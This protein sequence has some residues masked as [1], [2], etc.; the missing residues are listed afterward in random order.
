MDERPPKASTPRREVTDLVGELGEL[1]ETL[2]LD[3]GAAAQR[4]SPPR[5][6]L[7]VP[8]HRGSPR[9]GGP[10]AAV[11]E[12]VD[13]VPEPEVDEAL[14]DD[15]TLWVPPAEA[16]EPGGRPWSPAAAM[17]IVPGT[18]G[19]TAQVVVARPGSSWLM[20]AAACAAMVGAVAA[21]VVSRVDLASTSGPDHAISAPPFTV[22]A[23]RTVAA[24]SVGAVASAPTTTR[25]TASTNHLFIDIEYAGATPDDS[26]ELRVIHDSNPDGLP[27]PTVVQDHTYSL[28]SADGNGT[29]VVELT[30]PTGLPFASGRYTVSVVHGDRAAQSV[31]FT[32]GTARTT[33]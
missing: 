31:D 11:A 30:A 25:F 6:S 17:E 3:D 2:G 19:S 33:G 18:P 21:V 5:Q 4:A 7:P 16:L 28:T 9:A 26:L 22:T 24:D 1:V 32:V 15:S 13:D 23:L 8:P 27:P 29:V 14:L 20:T 10:A 12:A